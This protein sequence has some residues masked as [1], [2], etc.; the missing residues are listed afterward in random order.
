MMT[1]IPH[2]LQ[3]KQAKLHEIFDHLKP[4]LNKLT[5]A[6]CVAHLLLQMT[7]DRIETMLEKG[8]FSH[9]YL[10]VPLPDSTLL[11]QPMPRERKLTC[12]L[13]AFLIQK[14]ASVIHPNEDGLSPVHL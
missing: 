13:L 7:P 4:G 10:P 11:M 5:V 3:H 9:K 6:E 14:G 2:L 12:K 8:M 1:T